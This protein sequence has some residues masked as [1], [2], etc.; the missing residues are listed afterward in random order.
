MT[1]TDYLKLTAYFGERQRLQRR[2]VADALLDLYGDSDVAISVML[3][4]IASFGP[5]HH[6]R[7]DE[8]LTGSEDP[9][10]AVAAVDTADKISGLAEQTVAAI[11]RGLITLERAQ[12]IRRE[13]PKTTD[14]CK[15]T[16]YVG[17]HHRVAG[18]PAYRAVCDVLHRHGFAA[19]TVFLGVDGTAHGQ[20]RRAAFFSRNTDVPL[21]I[22]GLG[23]GAQVTAALR[24]VDQILEHPLLTVERAQLCKRGGELLG[25]PAELPGSDAEGRPLWQKLMVHTCET[26]QHDGVP[27]HREIVRALLQTRT[28]GGATVLRGVWGFSGEGKPHGDKMFQLGRQVPVTTIVVDTPARIAASFEIIDELTGEHGVVSSEMVP[29]AT[30]VDAGN[31]FGGTDLARFSY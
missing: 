14:Y 7:S 18:A 2:F 10:I 8:T 3:R 4:G 1:A 16:V 19:A 11:P 25:R 6:L 29:S 15:L 26:T 31:R 20:R 5:H 21:M 9:P 27:I 13:T 23:T 24:D 12:L 28:A 22:V 17:R 30:I